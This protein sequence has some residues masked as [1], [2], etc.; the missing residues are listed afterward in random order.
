MELEAYVQRVLRASDP[1][2]AM[3]ELC[4]LIYDCVGP[5]TVTCY[6]RT[7]PDLATVIERVA[8]SYVSGARGGIPQ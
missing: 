5:P 8:R 2:L 1:D 7:M 4:V 6:G 3:S